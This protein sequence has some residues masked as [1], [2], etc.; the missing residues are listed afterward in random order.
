MCNENKNFNNYQEIL[1]REQ[2]ADFFQVSIRTIDSWSEGG[3][4]NPSKIGRKVYFFKSELI[5]L[6]ESNRKVGES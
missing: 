1:T 4:L 6:L 2:A 3:Y 5:E